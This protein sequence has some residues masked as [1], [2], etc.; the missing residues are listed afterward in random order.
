[1]IDV[2]LDTVGMMAIWNRRD[3][4]HAAAKEAM[5]EIR[6][7]RF[8]IITS[9]LVL[10]KCGNAAARH[11]FRS[12]VKSLRIELVETNK[13]IEPTAADIGQAWAAYDRGE[14]NNAEIVHQVSFVVMRKLGLT[15][16][17]TNDAHF[18]AAGFETMF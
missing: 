2:F 11:K 18:R 3:Q 17:F 7:K 10:F 9:T 13:L 8:G 14:A 4:W 15:H 5:G 6:S 12:L 16:A 1:M